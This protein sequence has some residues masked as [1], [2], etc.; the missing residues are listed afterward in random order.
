MQTGKT[1]LFMACE[2]DQLSV[3]K[4]LVEAGGAEVLMKQADEVSSYTYMSVYIPVVIRR[5]VCRAFNVAFA[6]T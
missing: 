6:F 3:V 1:C 5:S 4:Y 2:Y